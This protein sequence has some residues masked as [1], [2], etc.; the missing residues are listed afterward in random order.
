M[1]ATVSLYTAV[2]ID[3]PNPNGFAWRDAYTSTWTIL[4]NNGWDAVDDV[5]LSKHQF[6]GITAGMYW[7]ELKDQDATPGSELYAYYFKFTPIAGPQT[8]SADL[9]GDGTVNFKDFAIFAS[10]WM[11]N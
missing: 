3:G 1:T 7:V 4:P 8:L 5:I 6:S 11:D 2:N 10:Q 9:N